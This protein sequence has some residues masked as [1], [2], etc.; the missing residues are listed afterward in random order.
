MVIKTF[1]S[2]P[3]E[4]NSYLVYDE[5]SKEAIIID[6]PPESAENVLHEIK[7]N[8]LSVKYIVNTHGHIDHVEDNEILKKELKAK[9]L[10]HKE[11][12]FWLNPSEEVKYFLPM[13]QTPSEADDFLKEGDILNIGD[14]NFSV[15]FTPG[16]TTGG[17]CLS[18]SQKKVLF[19]GDTL[20]KETIGR[21]DLLGGS[22]ET[23]INSIK[24]KILTLPDETLVYP[25]HYESTTIENEKKFNEYLN[26]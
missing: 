19:S 18:E 10:I 4:T 11:D 13:D 7:K 15:I 6:A 2:G 24:T 14:M 22:M 5:T 3:F 12:A 8:N 16:H 25:G 23:L 9:L 20:F 26:N 1:V 17:I 21:T